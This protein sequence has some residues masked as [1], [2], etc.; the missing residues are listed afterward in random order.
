GRTP[1]N[2]L[3]IGAVKTNLGHLESAAGV[4]GLIKAALSLQHEAIPPHLNLTQ[5]SPFM[6][7]ANLPLDVPTTLVPWPRT[8]EPR[9][10][11][12]SSF[13]FSGTNAHVILEEAPLPEPDSPEIERPA[14][15]LTLSGK[16]PVALRERAGQIRAF[17]EDAPADFLNI[18]HTANAGRSHFNHRLALNAT[19]PDEI[20][21]R[22]TMWL[23]GEETIGLQV[24]QSA[25][26]PEVAFLFSGQ[27]EQYVNMG[28]QL[29]ETQPVFRAALDEC[30]DL[31]QAHLPQSLLSVLYPESEAESP[32][33]QMTYAQPAIFS[34]EYAL[35]KLWESWGIR[36]AMVLGHSVGEYAAAC[37]AGVFTLADGLK[38]VT[39]RGRLMDSLPQTGA[40][41][42]VFADEER[43][44]AAV[45]PY[46]DR[47]SIA[48]VNGPGNVVISGDKTALAEII[49][50]LK[51]ERIRSRH[52]AVTQASHSPLME[53]MLDEFE[54]IARTVRFHAPQ[55]GYVSATL[56][57][58]ASGS[59]VANAAYWRRHSREAVQFASAAQ[60]LYDEGLRVFIEAG[61]NPTLLSNA[62][63]VVPEEESLWLPSL[64]SGW[65]DWTQILDSLGAAYVAGVKVDWD[66][67][68]RPYARHKL[69]IPTYPWEEGRYW[70]S[71]AASGHKPA[72][73]TWETIAQAGQ[74]QSNQGPLDLSAATYPAKWESLAK[75]TR[76][77]II[78]TLRQLGAFSKAG[79]R[80]T[81][82]DLLQKLGIA[83]TYDHLLGR[84]LDNLSEAGLIQRGA[85][86][87]TN[88]APLPD[89]G[90]AAAL[91][92][93]RLVL[94]DIEPLVDYVQDCGEKSASVLT[95]K[96][97]PLETLFPGGDYARVEYLYNGCPMAVYSNNIVT[98]AALAAVEAAGGRTLRMLEV[99]AGTG[100]T[101]AAVLPMLPPDRVTYHFTDVSDFFLARAQQKFAAFP[102]VSYGLLNLESDPREQGYEFGGFD[103]ILAS[104]VLHATRNLNHT[105]QSVRDLLAPGGILLLYET[106]S[107]LSWYDMTTGLIEG[108]QLFEDD[109]RGDNPLLPAPRWEEA[110]RANGFE[111]VAA[112]PEPGMVTTAL[113]QHVILAQTPGGA[114]GLGIAG[115][116][117]SVTVTTVPVDASE[118]SVMMSATAAFLAELEA[119]P[120]QDRLD[121]MVDFVR[122]Q[123]RR[124]LRLEASHPLDRRD[125]LMDIGFDSLMAVELR[126][127]LGGALALPEKLPATLMFDFPTP[128]AIAGY[129]LRLLGLA[130]P[131]EAA[132][133]PTPKA[134]AAPAE[135]AVDVGGLSDEEVEA[136]LLNKLKDIE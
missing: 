31:L 86:I 76:A 135:P 104:N 40:M 46:Q 93:A 96:E 10:A 49:E 90:L 132:P 75:L 71:V 56:G 118:G 131:V 83:P 130:E 87:Y 70:L 55:V 69:P 94:A 45:A 79:E 77:Y 5:L 16:S 51:A 29:Y 60:A 7:W 14:H 19:T 53:P 32:L 1:D 15:I 115:Q 123:V 9:F 119:T 92:E 103:V 91:A 105:L 23:N 12:V 42:A 38:L 102:F 43:V 116:F 57:R 117:G 107:H 4:A 58:L 101:T 73:P 48:V 8:D 108:W 2:R 28:R 95:G 97:S 126:S 59:E 129:L 124:V 3:K 88:R 17:L 11:G 81:V 82:T 133:V 30:D 125:R 52:L 36:P 66:G 98:A 54:G 134:P 121:T 72:K 112:F 68:D 18:L 64:R 47:V 74:R 22:L 84:W 26:V 99:G 61:P 41:V 114:A 67:F 62:R 127:R 65:E 6:D 122:D 80:H 89:P 25:A 27:G 34:I 63:R 106:T 44:V 113:G 111:S 85:G 33:E 50:K 120:L 24:G 128:E 20:R 39:A 136:L 109:W 35:A 37:I 21:E 100:G 13:G 78:H 110:L